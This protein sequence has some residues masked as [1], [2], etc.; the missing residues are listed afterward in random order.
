[1]KADDPE[2]KLMQHCFQHGKEIA[3]ADGA[4]AA[5]L[6]PLGYRI[7]RID[8]VHA[9]L[10]VLV[11]L[12]HGIHPNKSGLALGLWHSPVGDGNL[13]GLGVLDPD[14]NSAIRCALPKVI[15]VGNR[16][17]RQALEFLASKNFKL[18]F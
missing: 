15:D 18:P 12:M 13:A 7:H 6:L 8:V 9:S 17:S 5:Y 16:D 2:G 14:T 4:H 3:F 1:M 10:A 11:A